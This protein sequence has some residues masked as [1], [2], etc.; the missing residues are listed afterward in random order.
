MTKIWNA[1]AFG[2]ILGLAGA[3]LAA[4]PSFDEVDKNK[5]GSISKA[6]A[7]VVPTLDF[8]KADTNKDGKLDRAEYAA[9]IS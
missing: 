1:I 7:G 3:A 5:D 9:A 8:A 4:P 6:E 2:L